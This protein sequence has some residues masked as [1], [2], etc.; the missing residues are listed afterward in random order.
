[1]SQSGLQAV[2]NPSQMFLS[3]EHSNSEFLAGLAVAVLMDGSRAFL[4]EIQVILNISLR[5]LLLNA[6]S[7]NYFIIRLFGNFVQ[8]L[9][10]AGSS[11]SVSRQVNGV[12]ASRADMIIA[13]SDY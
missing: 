3:E 4:L 7:G 1:M 12:Q 8:A 9:C 6:F 5:A 11:S 13:V 10:I 2:S